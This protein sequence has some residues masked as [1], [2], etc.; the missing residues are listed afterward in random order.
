MEDPSLANL[1]LAPFLI[2]DVTVT[3]SALRLSGPKG[4]CQVE[5][6]VMTLL[7]VMARRPGELW[8]RSDLIDNVWPGDLGSDQSLS[9]AA[10]HLRKALSAPHGMSD[11]IATVP[12]L[13][14]RLDAK[15]ATQPGQTRVAVL[16]FR[17]LSKDGDQEYFADGLVDELIARLVQ[18]P[19]LM[20]A[21]RT[22]SFQFRNSE[23]ILPDIAARLRVDH[24]IEGSVQHQ[25]EH[26][27]I[28][29]CLIDGKTGFE[30][31]SYRFAGK[32]GDMF[33]SRDEVAAA[34]TAG[35]S[36]ALNVAQPALKPRP[37][38][39]NRLAYG[40][41]LQGRALTNRAFGEGLLAKA[42][43]LLE[44]ALALDPDFAECWT[45][46][47]EA[48]VNSVVYTPC[49][50]RQ[51]ETE[52]MAQ[53]ARRAIA[54]DPSQGHAR[55]MLALQRWTQNDAVG[56]LDLAY[57]AYRLEPENPDVIIRL[58]S[59]LL[60]CGRTQEAL[61]LIEAAIDRDPVY[62]RNYAMLCVAHLNLGHAEESIAAGQRMVDLGF[63]SMLLAAATATAG[64]RELAV[65]QYWQTRLLMNT[66]IFPPVGSAPLDADGLDAYWLMAAK[67]V[68]SGLEEDR[69]VYCQLLEMLHVTLHDPFDPSIVMPAVWMG[70]AP[71]V[72]KTLGKQIT[73]ANMISLMLIWADVDPIRSVWQHPDFMHFATHIGLVAAWDKYGW[74]DLLP[75]PKEGREPSETRGQG[76]R[77]EPA[78]RR[79]PQVAL[80]AIRGEPGPQWP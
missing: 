75:R 50:D 45:A 7:V 71:M 5:P 42:I 51:G 24:L 67:G 47:A 11:A 44:Q 29:I 61:P 17:S 4:T 16:P 41:Y 49:L 52:I 80:G 14:Y 68:C 1:G 74:P 18:V 10:S 32:V 63:P 35:L 19:E 31:W 9:R 78:R 20:V 43:D 40:L 79:E 36:E 54:L 59:F 15:I 28:D 37:M 8:L 48:H 23:L 69:N 30:T 26:V 77:A 64:E 60:Y 70:N 21:G 55:S 2:G 57:E 65:Q 22:S 13:G 25:D 38:T 56:A 58:G 76:D 34:V 27:R 53:C 73:P 62:G 72:F 66:V 39:D 33:V 12:K 46:L 3:P 6:K